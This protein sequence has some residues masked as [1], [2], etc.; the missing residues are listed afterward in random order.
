M[1]MPVALTSGV[2]GAAARLGV[3]MPL[4]DLP[5]L[6]DFLVLDEA[7]LGFHNQEALAA[8]EMCG[9][10]CAIHGGECDLHAKP[11]G[12]EGGRGPFHPQA[13]VP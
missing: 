11:S 13:A 3:I 12:G 9:N 7:T 1:I 6:P 2:A 10:G 8:T 4:S 5:V